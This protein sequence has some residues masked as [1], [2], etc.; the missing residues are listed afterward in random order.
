MKPEFTIWLSDAIIQATE[1][2]S[3][4]TRKVILEIW[5]GTDGDEALPTGA[6]S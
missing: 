1:R 6:I 5:P 4:H 3:P 2:Y